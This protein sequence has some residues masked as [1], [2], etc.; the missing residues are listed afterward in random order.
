MK[1]VLAFHITDNTL[2][3][4]SY[5]ATNWTAK[6]HFMVIKSRAAHWQIIHALFLKDAT[7]NTSKKTKKQ[8]NE[9][10]QKG[11]KKRNNTLQKLVRDCAINN[12]LI[13]A[14]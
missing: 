5:A 8:L 10:A 1:K 9:K 6:D 12:Y 2:D 4:C 11:T 14:S 7:Y 3:S 13:F